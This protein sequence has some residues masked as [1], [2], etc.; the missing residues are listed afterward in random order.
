MKDYPLIKVTL[1]Y[2]LGIILAKVFILPLNLDLQLIVIGSLT[3]LFLL[4][5]LLKLG[6]LFSIIS[7]SLLIISFGIVSYSIAQIS[8]HPYPF[9][10]SKIQNAEIFGMIED[11]EL[12]REYE[13]RMTVQVDSVRISGNLTRLNHSFLCR[14]RDESRKNLDSIYNN[15]SVGNYVAIKGTITKG[16]EQRN[17]GEFDYQYYL[18]QKGISGLF[19]SYSTNDFKITNF[20][21][22]II[23]NLILD[24][25]KAIDKSITELHDAQTSALLKGLLVGDRTEIND[26]TKTDFINTGVVH[27]LAVSGLHVAYILVIFLFV[28]GRLNLYLRTTLTIIGIF[29]FI[30]VTGATASVVRSAIMGIVILTAFLSNRS[31]N[32]YNSIS[33]SALI[34]LIINPIDL[35]DPGLQLSF[36][37]VI[38]IVA[39]TPFFKKRIN[40]INLKNNYLKKLLLFCTVSLAAQIGT[41]PFTLIY[42]RKLSLISLVANIIIVPLTGAMISIGILTLV[43][44]IVWLK[45]AIVY[46]SVNNLATAFLYWIAHQL[47]S[48]KFS[49]LA[50]RQFSVLDALIFYFLIFIIF[51]NYEKFVI[52]KTKFILI[53]LTF[54]NILIL[55]SLDNKEYLPKNKLSITAIDVGQGDAFLLKFPNGK[56]ALIDAGEATQYF[57]NGERIILPLLQYLGVDKIDYGFISHVDSD[58]YAGFVSLVHNGVIQEIYKPPL[59][60]SY[61]KDIRLEK[62]LAENQVLVHHYNKNILKIGDARIY[63]LYNPNDNEFSKFKMNDRSGIIKIVY[64]NNSFL[65][66]GDA[67]KKAESKLINNFAGFLQSDLLKL[68]HHGS[69]T[70]SSTKFLDVVNPKYA[71]IS[72]GQ[73]NKFKHPSPITL[74]RVQ[75]RNINILRTDKLGCIMLSSDG[76]IIKNMG[77]R[78]L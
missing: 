52:A 44:G 35:F 37:A 51:Y 29:L 9:N 47:S 49:F 24:A 78:R 25:R 21:N 64:G 26:E 13:I 30:Y 75:E 22:K 59:D 62:F 28:F 46:A 55:S 42:F 5:R 32:I 36:A 17:P 23:P 77:W 65:F 16:R 7:I 34:I 69:S 68:G 60:T 27:V 2:V 71:L 63:F 3:T 20:T 33:L 67:E 31:T 56:T 43:L 8:I 1:C 50:I 57:D 53:I 41:L 66:V 40:E 76:E 72:A 14:V 6:D 18:E 58:H 73:Y 48:F 39:L 38:A 54:A 45:A 10:D 4:S 70:G 15:S 12:N 74:Q 19:T 11:I 61:K